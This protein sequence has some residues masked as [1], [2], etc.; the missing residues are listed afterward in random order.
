MKMKVL[1]AGATGKTGLQIVRYLVEQGH[2]PIALVRESSDTSGLPAEVSLRQGDLTNLQAGVCD[3]MDAVVFAAGSG[4]ATGPELTDKV[5]RDGA[6]RLTDLACEA[7]VERF[8][9]LSS[10]GADQA[11][12]QG[13][14]AHYLKAKH[15]ADAYLEASGLTYAI[16]RPVRLTD[17]GRKEDVILGDGV[18]RTATASRA[19]VAY[20]LAKAATTHVFDGK[21]LDMQAAG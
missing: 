2:C 16:L 13:D 4:G 15:D 18:D 5:D 19:D 7:G 3:G 9:M 14:L 21:T 6:K 11:H 20:L 17:A 10:I 1:V 12:P 8:V